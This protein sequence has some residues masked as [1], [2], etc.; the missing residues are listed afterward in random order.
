MKCQGRSMDIIVGHCSRDKVN[1]HVTELLIGNL[2]LV[3]WFCN[4]FTS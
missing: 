1:F 2:D 4:Q 3:S